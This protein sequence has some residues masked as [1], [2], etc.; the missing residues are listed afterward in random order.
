MDFSGGTAPVDGSVL[1]PDW[2]VAAI[3][4]VVAPAEVD[5]SAD[6]TSSWLSA[7]IPTLCSGVGGSKDS[8][9]FITPR[10]EDGLFTGTWKQVHH[11]TNKNLQY[12]K[13]KK[14]SSTYSCDFFT[15]KF[16]FRRVFGASIALGLL[17]TTP[18]EGG[19]STGVAIVMIGKSLPKAGGCKCSNTIPT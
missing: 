12:S 14:Y 1:V 17:I 11:T 16:I 8:P 3:V 19:I 5:L 15:T 18:A 4:E 9:R 2:A 10:A 13:R 6:G 7:E